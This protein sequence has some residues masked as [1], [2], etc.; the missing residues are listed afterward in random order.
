MAASSRPAFLVQQ[1][2]VALRRRQR[3]QR[4]ADARAQLPARDLGLGL[5]GAGTGHAVERVDRI[6]LAAAG[7]VGRQHQ[8]PARPPV[9]DQPVVRDPIEPG[10]EPGA[11]HVACAR[12]DTLIQMS[13]KSSSAS[14]ARPQCRN[15]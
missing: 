5:V 15:R 2:R 14:G 9:V 7:E 6:V 11:R 1:E 10:R 13:W 4:G 3:G 8:H 12:P